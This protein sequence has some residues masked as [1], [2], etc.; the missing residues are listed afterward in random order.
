MSSKSHTYKSL[1]LL[2]NFRLLLFLQQNFKKKLKLLIKNDIIMS[3][4]DFQI[5]IYFE[6]I[7]SRRWKKILR[8]IN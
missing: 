3:N 2:T 6:I 8:L 4:S 1:K 7:I 5:H